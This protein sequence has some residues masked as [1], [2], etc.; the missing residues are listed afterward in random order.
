[1]PSTL[2]SLEH[3]IATEE[4]PPLLKVPLPFPHRLN[5]FIRLWNFKF[6]VYFFLKI[7][8]LVYPPAAA[9][10]PTLVTRYSCRPGLENGLFFPKGYEGGLLGVYFNVHG[11]G[12]A[13][14]DPQ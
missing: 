14:C 4:A 7:H 6:V 11:G 12:F 13:V 5:C 2:E 3:N 9:L 8:R 10:R 1:M